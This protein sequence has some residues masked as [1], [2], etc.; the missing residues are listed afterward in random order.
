MYSVY[1][2]IR[3]AYYPWLV[4][5][6]WGL[7]AWVDISLQETGFSITLSKLP[8]GYSANITILEIVIEQEPLLCVNTRALNKVSKYVPVLDFGPQRHVVS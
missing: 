1:F 5:I 7:L 3:F 8:H 4:H 2:P 6:L